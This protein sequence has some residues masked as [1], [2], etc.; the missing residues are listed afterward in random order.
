MEVDLRAGRRSTDGALE[1]TPR[2]FDLLAYLAE[3]AG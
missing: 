3:R 1:L 2:E